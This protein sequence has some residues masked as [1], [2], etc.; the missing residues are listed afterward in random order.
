M[1]QRT[2]ITIAAV[3][4][5]AV[6]AVGAGVAAGSH[7]GNRASHSTATSSGI[8]RTAAAT[9]NGKT[10]T[11]LVNGRGLPLYYYA[12]DRPGQSLVSGGLAALWPP[13]TSAGRA[14]AQGLTGSLTV[15]RDSHGNQVAY[16]GHLLY[17]FYRD[18]SGVVTG[19]AVENFF[20]ATPTLSPLAGTSSSGSGNGTGMYGGGG[21]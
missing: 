10:E 12:P 2:Q 13:E 16:N 7:G 3:G 5:A 1:L 20:L 4:V 15:V 6:V 8:V 19:Q 21:Y 9:V 14:T 17:T 11:I 18:Q